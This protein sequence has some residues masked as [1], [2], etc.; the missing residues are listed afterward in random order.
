MRFDNDRIFNFALL[1]FSFAIL[2]FILAPIFNLLIHFPRIQVDQEVIAAL[3]VS[4]ISATIATLISLTFGVPLSYLLS[5]KDF[6]GKNLLTILVILPLVIPPVVG[7]ILLLM[8]YG[9]QTLLSRL[10]KLEF[11]STIVGIIIAQIFIASPY[12]II[13]AKSSFDLI[14]PNLE[15]VS[16]LL[17]R[18]RLETFQRITLPL[19]KKGILAGLMLTWTRSL[20]EFGATVVMAYHPYSMPVK[21]WADFTGRGLSYA[22]PSVVLLLMIPFTVFLILS[23]LEGGDDRGRV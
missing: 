17:G 4:L 6:R 19:A 23:F 15:K 21:I 12:L 1:L 3:K 14:N 5:R 13:S 7:G 20:G 22:L 2:S 8:I 18:G 9:P 10:L 11:T 16:L